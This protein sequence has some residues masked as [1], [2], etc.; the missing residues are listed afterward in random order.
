[1]WVAELKIIVSKSVRSCMSQNFF[2][3]TGSGRHSSVVTYSEFDS[4]DH[5]NIIKV[6][7]KYLRSHDIGLEI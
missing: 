3:K 7:E 1:M 2:L 4:R 5:K 6:W